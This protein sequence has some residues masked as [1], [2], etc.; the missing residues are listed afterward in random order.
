MA[1]HLDWEKD[2]PT[3][4]GDVL[5]FIFRNA[6]WIFTCRGC[7]WMPLRESLRTSAEDIFPISLQ[8]CVRLCTR[9]F[10]WVSVW[11]AV[12]G[13]HAN[14]KDPAPISKQLHF[15]WKLVSRERDGRMGFRGCVEAP[16]QGLGTNFNIDISHAS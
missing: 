11:T 13:V 10:H 1:S 7:S 9:M 3:V 6:L 4:F 14:A 12:E 15:E 5:V 8:A 2:I 16:V